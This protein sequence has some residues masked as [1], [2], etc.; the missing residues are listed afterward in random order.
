M[1]SGE[2]VEDDAG[3]RP[4]GYVP[5]GA[6]GTTAV[7][8]Q[9][10]VVKK[11]LDFI[12]QQL[13]GPGGQVQ[14]IDLQEVERLVRHLEVDRGELAKRCQ[15]LAEENQDLM[16]ANRHLEVDLA[17]ARRELDDTRRQLKHQQIDLQMKEGSSERPCADA[18]QPSA[19]ERLTQES[20][21]ALQAAMGASS[22][23]SRHMSRSELIRALRATQEELAVQRARNQKLEHRRMLDGHRCEVLADAAERQRLE[24]TAMRLGKQR[25]LAAHPQ[26]VHKPKMLHHLAHTMP[27]SREVKPWAG[28]EAFGVPRSNS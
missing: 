3:A 27:V 25:K 11:E 22:E 24:L 12:S 14:R 4:S 18:E 9:L 1:Q 20:L 15:R 10:A 6:T 17:E 21:E 23:P 28:G 8:E 19:E 2:H 5:S 26:T 16:E 7:R 13:R